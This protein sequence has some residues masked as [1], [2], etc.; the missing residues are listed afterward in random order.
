MARTRKTTLTAATLVVLAFA[1]LMLA[2]K[3]EESSG[4]EKASPG[5]D[6]GRLS[7][8]VAKIGEETLTLDYV[9]SSAQRQSPLLRRELVDSTKRNEF[10][11]KLINMELLAQEAKKRG[12]EDHPEVASVR[13][14]Q[15]ASLMHRKIADDVADAEPT[16][17]ELRKYYEEHHGDYHKPEKVRVRHILISD[18]AAAAKLLNEIK[19]KKVSQH[20]FRRMAQEQS[21]DEDTKLRGGDLTF[22]TRT[23][24]R[25]EEDEPQVPE[26]VVEAAFKLDKNGAIYPELIKS[27]QG[28]HIVM[29]TG[30]R[31]KMDL[32][33]EDAKERLT[34]LVRREK[35]KD[36]IENAIDG[37]KK[38]F[39]VEA[40][41]ENLKYVVIDLS[42]GPSNR[43]QGGGHPAVRPKS[44]E[45]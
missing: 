43:E 23:A 22:L 16:D 6:E 10:V 19:K 33:F 4:A 37:L 45:K 20:E 38:K 27:E 36:A 42:V 28:Y 9:E 15:L 18:K 30:H 25:K 8:P 11:E 17:D 2:A 21:Q 29:R 40:F 24:D 32:S 1:L 41:E 13:K 12:Y 39:P 34:V 35:R 7:L 44:G 14:N 31:D 5:T 26:Q 3:S